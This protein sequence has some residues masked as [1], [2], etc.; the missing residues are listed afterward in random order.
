MPRTRILSPTPQF[1]D[2]PVEFNRGGSGDHRTPAEYPNY[3]QLHRIGIFTPSTSRCRRLLCRRY[4]ECG[5][6]DFVGRFRRLKNIYIPYSNDIVFRIS[7]LFHKHHLCLSYVNISNF[8]L[9]L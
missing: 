4:V 3:P 1:G 9:R 6:E 2:L 5:D 7:V 8:C